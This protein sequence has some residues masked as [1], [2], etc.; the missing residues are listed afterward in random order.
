MAIFT[1]SHVLFVLINYANFHVWTGP[2]FAGFEIQEKFKTRISEIL[3]NQKDEMT[4]KR[5]FIQDIET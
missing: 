4:S 1:L 5:R 2:V 3:G